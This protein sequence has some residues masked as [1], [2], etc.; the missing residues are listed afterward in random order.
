M[1]GRFESLAKEIEEDLKAVE[2]NFWKRTCEISRLE[3][4]RSKKIRR[5]EVNGNI[6]HTIDN[7]QLTW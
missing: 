5:M 4:I 2:M 1:V 7:R 6:L 3:C